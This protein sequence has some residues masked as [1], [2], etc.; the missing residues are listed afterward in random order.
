MNL[1]KHQLYLLEQHIVRGVRDIL[2]QILPKAPNLAQRSPMS[3]CLAPWLHWGMYREVQMQP[4]VI[5]KA[6]V[7]IIVVTTS[8]SCC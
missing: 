1:L 8:S 2:V 5:V 3:Y 4:S 7:L 6:G